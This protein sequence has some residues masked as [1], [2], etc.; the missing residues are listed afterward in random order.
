[1]GSK[2]ND[3]GSGMENG[4]PDHGYNKHYKAKRLGKPHGSIV[5]DS[6]WLRNYKMGEIG[7]IIFNV[8]GLSAYIIGILTNWNNFI[9]ALLG[10]IGLLYAAIKCAKEMEDYRYRKA[11]RKEK[12][13]NVNKYLNEK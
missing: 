9:S 11:E 1:M 7:K 8:A 3:I 5:Y 6:A 12:E 10:V 4:I 2:G 13:H